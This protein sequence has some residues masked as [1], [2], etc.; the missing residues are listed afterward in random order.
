[1]AAACPVPRRR[2]PKRAASRQDV[3]F[4]PVPDVA[5]VRAGPTLSFRQGWKADDAL[6]SRRCRSLGDTIVISCGRRSG[7]AASPGGPVRR[8]RAICDGCRRCDGPI[9]EPFDLKPET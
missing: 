3:R 6:A 5:A 9:G 8:G 7:S 1:M 2:F 4:P